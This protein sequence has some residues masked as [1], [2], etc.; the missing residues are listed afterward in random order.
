VNATS[1][2]DGQGGQRVQICFFARVKDRAVLDRVEFYAQ[3]IRILR[4]LGYDVHVATRLR[5]L[6]RAD[7]YFCWWWTWAFVPLA[8]ASALRRPAVVTGTFDEW[9]YDDRP[10]LQRRLLTWALRT[11]DVN[12]FVSELEAGVVPRRFPTRRSVYSPHVVDT[13]VYSPASASRAREPLVLTVAW[14]HADN[15]ERKGIAEIVRAAPLVRARVPGVRF[16][17]VGERASGYP[18]LQAQADELGVGDIVEFRGVVSADEKIALMRRCGAYLQPSRFE[19]FG[20]AVLEAMSCGAPVVTS[21]GGALP[22]V[23]GDA[24]VVLDDVSPPAIADA[25]CA[26]LG[27]PARAHVLGARARARAEREFSYARRR[28]DLA[29]VLA[30]LLPAR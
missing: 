11:A 12:V 17:I 29:R 3:D 2:S 9:L 24:G 28:D 4:D 22:E 15:A 14:L 5:E 26:L 1:P 23:V 30:D 27:D 6:V 13:E 19:G 21:A 25:V 20:L 18:A 7:L 10:W 8:L 16:V